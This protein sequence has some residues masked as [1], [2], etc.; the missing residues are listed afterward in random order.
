MPTHQERGKSK[1]KQ[2][3][4]LPSAELCTARVTPAA[5]T[6]AGPAQPTAGGRLGRF[7]RTWCGQAVMLGQG[8]PRSITADTVDIT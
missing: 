8:K 2:R 6:R 1:A 7:T 3:N 4:C 5:G